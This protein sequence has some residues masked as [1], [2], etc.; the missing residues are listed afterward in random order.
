MLLTLNEVIYAPAQRSWPVD[1]MAGRRRRAAVLRDHH[2]AVEAARRALEH[3]G[4]GLGLG[5]AVLPCDGCRRALVVVVVVVVVNA[6]AAAAA[7]VL[8]L[9][10]R[11]AARAL[12]HGRR[13]RRRL[14]QC[15]WG[16]GSA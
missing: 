15:H 11:L 6:L 3:L 7:G 13:A 12:D 16:K 1:C 9:G 4:L 2:L 10:A 5:L 14:E 8:I